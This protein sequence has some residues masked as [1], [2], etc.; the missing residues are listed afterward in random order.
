GCLSMKYTIKSLSIS[1]ASSLLNLSLQNNVMF[2]V[3][4]LNLAASSFVS[5]ELFNSSSV[6]LAVISRDR[7]PDLRSRLAAAQDISLAHV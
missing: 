6:V 2:F 3:G 5:V 4:D 7:V 1:I